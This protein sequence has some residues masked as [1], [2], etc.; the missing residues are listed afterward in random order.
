MQGPFR[1]GGYH[2]GQGTV[3]D[4]NNINVML[5]YGSATDAMLV[6]DALN[7]YMHNNTRRSDPKTSRDAER[8]A[9]VYKLER[10]RKQA[11]GYFLKYGPLT[12]E[13]L[14][15]KF[16]EA[17]AKITEARVRHLRLELLKMGL[18]IERKDL[19]GKTSTGNIC[20]VFAVKTA[21]SQ[22]HD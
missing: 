6:V 3:S 13:Q 20:R 14:Y 5:V 11:Y 15:E 17:Q 10:W 21:S 19:T 7:S 16:A 1:L 8:S 12:D 4:A 2:S 22:A 18:I 9:P